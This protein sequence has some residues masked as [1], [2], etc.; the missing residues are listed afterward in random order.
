M[1]AKLAKGIPII[2]RVV[3]AALLA[4][5]SAFCVMAPANGGELVADGPIP[6]IPNG[7]DGAKQA[8]DAFDAIINVAPDHCQVL[9]NIS[10][11]EYNLCLAR[12][13][14]KLQQEESSRNNRKRHGGSPMANGFAS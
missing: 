9:R 12:A 7:D 5:I 1:A 3:T 2:M 11:A 10:I 14:P 8:A 4:V 6:E 13:Y